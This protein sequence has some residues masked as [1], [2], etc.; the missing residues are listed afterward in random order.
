MFQFRKSLA[1]FDESFD[2]SEIRQTR[3]RAPAHTFKPKSPCGFPVFIYDSKFVDEQKIFVK[4]F[5]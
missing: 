1:D 4:I 5:H 3:L 2:Q